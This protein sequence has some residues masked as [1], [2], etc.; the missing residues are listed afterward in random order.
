[1]TTQK[2]LSM[3]NIL[4]RYIKEVAR[5]IALPF[6]FNMALMY[7]NECRQSQIAHKE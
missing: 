5:Q 1:M 7:M 4:H 6:G 3:D 2:L